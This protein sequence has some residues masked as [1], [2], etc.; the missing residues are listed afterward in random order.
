MLH[1][2]DQRPDQGDLGKGKGTELSTETG[3]NALLTD[4]ENARK[5]FEEIQDLRRSLSGLKTSDSEET[6]GGGLKG[7]DAAEEDIVVQEEK[8]GGAGPEE[9]LAEADSS[10]AA[11]E[12]AAA[13]K[14]PEAAAPGA[15]AEKPSAA[16]ETAAEKVSAEAASGGA[17]AAE[18]APEKTASG[19]REKDS[20]GEELPAGLAAVIKSAEKDTRSVP[21]EEFAFQ[22]RRQMEKQ[23]Q[24]MQGKTDEKAQQKAAKAKAREELRRQKAARDEARKKER[25]QRAK[26]LQKER[27]IR[28]EIRRK[29]KIAKKSAEMGGGVIN[30]HDTT[31]STQIQP[32][33]EFSW[34]DL[35]GIAPRKEIQ[36]AETEA[37]RK[38]LQEEAEARKEEARLAAAQIQQARAGRYRSSA[39]G[40][41]MQKIT[42]F[43]DRHK[44]L[45]LTALGLV[46]LVCVGTAGVFNYC[47]AYE[48]SYNG[49]PLGYVKSKDEVLQI[50]D[51][52]QEALTEDKN[53]EVVIDTKDDITFRR[54]SLLDKDITPDTSDEVLRRLTYMGDV[55]VKAFG[56]YVNG[57]K[58]GAV[59]SKDS[60]AEVLKKIEDKYASG[61]KGA[62]IEK[63][64]ILETVDVEESN[65][66]LRSLSD[67]DEMVDIL[68]T[69]GNR[70][71]VHTVVA[72][73]T[74]DEIAQAYGTSE[75]KIIQDNEGVTPE[76]LTV[77]STLLI[78]QNAPLLTV[79][80]T[81]KRT[82]KETIK[83]ETKEEKTDE[84]YEDEE[85]V[86]QE[87][88][89]GSQTITERTVSING[90]I[91]DTQTDILKKEIT[92]KPVTKI[93]RI[94]TAERPPSVGDGVYIW[95]LDGGYTLTSRFGYRWGRLHAGI[96][97][98]CSSGHTVRA[99]DGG[100]VV[101]AGYFGG[102]GYCVDIDHQNGQS[103]RYGHLSSIIVNT[104]DEVYE[105][106]PIAYSGNSGRSTGPH[107]H[108][109]VHVNGSPQNPLNFLP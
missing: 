33:A 72:G 8:A 88:E 81:E 106:Q 28:S 90:E 79:R 48:Y 99:A 15:A 70:E 7:K 82:Y 95:P 80:I 42:A 59:D 12:K 3:R 25:W 52:V 37:E 10:E 71:T 27:E 83:Y 61:K 94:G 67:T 23:L 34:R 14:A 19:S 46:L 50:T 26:K 13:E 62:E 68:C 4:S 105:G 76:K 109:E 55:N 77:G 100:I 85:E 101:R 89:N 5:I 20:D 22:Y 47:T 87:G 73:E 39:F 57:E 6:P 51:L 44:T 40:R 17:K 16:E 75:A 24:A 104:G 11:S 36:A 64:E 93:V 60:A 31:V 56:V 74:L 86:T 65:T 102:Y 1:E 18:S 108:F 96:D 49:Y 9:K 84:M 2:G 53:I 54:V 92:K 41:R 43:C 78:R 32:V 21:E 35:L 29:K 91:D 38:A 45:L 30:L 103:T 98:G 63:A 97:L 58:V 66:D 69:S 107:L